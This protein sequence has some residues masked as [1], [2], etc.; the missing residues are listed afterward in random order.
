M[1]ES[2]EDEL[3]DEIWEVIDKAEKIGDDK[4]ERRNNNPR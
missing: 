3:T 4:N 2:A 1:S